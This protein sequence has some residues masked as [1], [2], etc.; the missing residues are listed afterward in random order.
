[1]SEIINSQDFIQEIVTS[2]SLTPQDYQ[3]ANRHG[4]SHLQTG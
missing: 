1:M 2:P 4:E 3:S